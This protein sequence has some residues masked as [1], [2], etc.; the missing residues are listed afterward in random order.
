MK[1]HKYVRVTIIF[2]LVSIIYTTGAMEEREKKTDSDSS[3]TSRMS[4]AEEGEEPE[5]KS[6][7]DSAGKSVAST[8]SSGVEAGDLSRDMVT[9][10]RI[11]FTSA[12]ERTFA[13]LLPEGE[14]ELVRR[15][16]DCSLRLYDK[17]QHHYNVILTIPSTAEQ[18]K[19]QKVR[20]NELA[21]EVFA[22]MLTEKA[23][24]AE[25]PAQTH[26]PSHH[27]KWY[28]RVKLGTLFCIAGLAYIA[29]G[30]TVAAI[31]LQLMAMNDVA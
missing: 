11:L 31:A 20:V 28:G 30:G 6:D 24:E 10:N 27:K 26:I 9:T 5:K 17:D 21:Q 29:A 8:I 7:S 13:K 22:Q 12:L 23:H 3:P 19:E 4:S 16:V 18:R 14:E 25:G 2:F 15:A 1:Y